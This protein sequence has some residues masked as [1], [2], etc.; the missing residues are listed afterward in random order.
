MMRFTVNGHRHEKVAME[1]AFGASLAG[2]EK[3][4]RNEARWA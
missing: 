4:L 3:F 1:V 2:K